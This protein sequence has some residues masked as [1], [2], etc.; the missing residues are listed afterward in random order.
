MEARLN[1]IYHAFTHTAKV[2]RVFMGDII[3]PGEQPRSGSS[4]M[5]SAS[6]RALGL[7]GQQ[8]DFIGRTIGDP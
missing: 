2:S 1:V 5:D 6:I 4:A 7:I 8:R 3:E